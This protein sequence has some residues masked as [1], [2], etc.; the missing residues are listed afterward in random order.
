MALTIIF[1]ILGGTLAYYNW[2]TSTAQQTKI[3]FTA[4]AAFSC[5]ADGGGDITSGQVNL[6]PTYCTDAQNAIKRTVTVN[7]VLNNQGENIMMDLWLN[8]DTLSTGLKDSTNFKYALTT[9]SSSCTDGK[10][11]SGNFNGKVQNDKVKLLDGKTYSETTEETY[12][13]WIWLDSAET[14]TSTMNQNFKLTLGGECTDNTQSSTSAITAATLVANANP[15]T[16]TYA[17]ATTAQKANM[18]AVSHEATDQTPATT[19]YRF[20]GSSPNNWIKFNGDEDW[21]IIG[22]FDGKIKIIKSTKVGNTN[23]RFDYKKTGVGSSTTDYGSNDWT[24][25][26]LM[27]ML[28][29]PIY[30]NSN[31]SYNTTLLA[32]EL[33]KT[34]YTIDGSNN[35]KDNKETPNIIYQLGKIPASTATGATSYSGTDATWSLT[36]EA[37]GQIEKSTFYLGGTTSGSKSATAWYNLERGSTTPNSNTNPKNWTGYVGLMYPSDYAYTYA[38]GVDDTCFNRTSSS[39]C[40]ATTGAKSWLWNDIIKNLSYP[41]I[42]PPYT[43]RANLVFCVGYNGASVGHYNAYYTSGV[44]PSIY[45]K[46]EIELEGSGTEDDPYEI[47]G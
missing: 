28:N 20:I 25:S 38:Y 9:G 18:W 34:G 1:T 37:I 3:T 13:L 27:Y 29:A 40:P 21:R 8:V 7:T 11:I 45:L 16:L 41:W 44:H 14:S 46:S 23:Y 5:S 2:Q 31:G 19:D 33:L 39:N 15:T 17:N 42:I 30:K 32:S 35:I 24:D 36:T 26:Q 12:Y 47:V 22:V 4:N 43:D 6:V 10:I